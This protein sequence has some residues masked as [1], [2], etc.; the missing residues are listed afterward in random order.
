L[1]HT[2]CAVFQKAKLIQKL[3]FFSNKPN[4]VI[5][6]WKPLQLY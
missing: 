5:W 6:K 3:Q 2:V 1:T 4:R